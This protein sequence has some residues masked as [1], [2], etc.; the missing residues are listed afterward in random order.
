[1]EVLVDAP[2]TAA[3][4]GWSLDSA[5]DHAGQVVVVVRTA[6]GLQA[7]VGIART[8]TDR[9]RRTAEHD[10][11]R[12]AGIGVW[13]QA[14]SPATGRAEGTDLTT[15]PAVRIVGELIRASA[16][17]AFASGAGGQKAGG[18]DSAGLRTVG[19]LAKTLVAC[20]ALR[21]GYSAGAA[22]G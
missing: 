18:E 10:T 6:V 19:R 16:A 15:H 20:L 22:I 1:V 3:H 2:A 12:D 17:A 14:L 13:H 5:V 8:G 21:A 7:V 4:P 11:V 9:A